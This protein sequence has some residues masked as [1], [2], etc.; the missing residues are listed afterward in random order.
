MANQLFGWWIKHGSAL[1][2]QIQF[3]AEPQTRS[4]VL[5]I[6][7]EDLWCFSCCQPHRLGWVRVTV[8]IIRELGNQKRYGGFPFWISCLQDHRRWNPVCLVLW[9]LR[10]CWAKAEMMTSSACFSA[11]DMMPPQSL[12]LLFLVCVVFCKLWNSSGVTA[13]WQQKSVYW[14]HCGYVGAHFKMPEVH[15]DVG[16]GHGKHLL[17][18]GQAPADGPALL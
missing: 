14:P 4:P 1:C 6:L 12:F 13:Q 11:F 3:G 5:L 17:E 9:K 2:R 18:V 10:V 7:S 15:V 8:R 16:G